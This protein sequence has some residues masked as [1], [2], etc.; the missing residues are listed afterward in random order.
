VRRLG[1]SNAKEALGQ[2]LWWQNRK[3]EVIGVI[4]DFHFMS[5][6]TSIEPFIVVMNTH[7]S[8]Q[9][10]SIKLQSGNP[11]ESIAE[12]EKVFHSIV[13]GQI[14]E[15]QF[16]NE[17]F[18]KQYKSEE[19]FMNVFT[20]FAIIAI[21]IAALGLYGLALFMTELKVRELGIRKVL[22]ATEGSLV[23][24]LTS[25]FLM[26][27]VVSFVIAGP[28]AYYVMNEWLQQFPMRENINIGLLMIAGVL[29]FTIALLT[30]SYQSVKAARANPVKAIRN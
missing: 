28:I 15:Y 14:F 11:S 2:K 23:Y 19:K 30:V 5:A 10:L 17:D 6:N 4:K 7:W 9:Y 24:L 12:I 25:N 20:F 18:D 21:V 26:L 16:L 22:G 8:V 29:A 27:V 1:F 13:P 3:G